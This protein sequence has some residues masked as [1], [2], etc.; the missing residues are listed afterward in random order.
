MFS[1]MGKEYKGRFT[2]ICKFAD[3]IILCMN[4]FL[5][6]STALILALSCADRSPS[7]APLAAPVI[8][9]ITGSRGADYSEAIISC[10]VSS[11]L[12]LIEFGIIWGKD[13]IVPEGGIVNKVFTARISGL[14]FSKTYPFRAFIGNGRTRV[15]SE[16]ETWSTEDETPPAPAIMKVVALPGSYA[17]HVRVSCRIPALDQVVQRSLLRCGVCYSTNREDPTLEGFS[18]KAEEIS[19]EGDFL[20]EVK[21]LTPSATY[22]MRPFAEIGKVVAYGQPVTVRV[23]S[24]MDIVMTEECEPSQTHVL[25]HGRVSPDW[26]P[27]LSAYGIDWDG[28]LIPAAGMDADGCF[29]VERSGL[30]PGKTYSYRAYATLEGMLYYGDKVSFTTPDLVIP[31]TEYVDLGLGVLWGIKNLGASALY[32]LGDKYAWGETTPKNSF[33]WSNYLWCDGTNRVTKYNT[34]DQLVLLPEDDAATEALHDGWRIPTVEE[35]REL[36]T[37]CRWDYGEVSNHPGYVVTSLEEGFEGQSFFIPVGNSAGVDFWSSSVYPGRNESFE[38]AWIFELFV[39]I[40]GGDTS[41]I[42][43][44]A[45][46]YGLRIRPVRERE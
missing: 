26:A 18:L 15:Y 24:E 37:K 10:E 38:N 20:L 31:E 44:G 46:C 35:W 7:E 25:M 29:S 32:A 19:P 6:L 34:P 3:R 2:E 5:T 16:T 22:W 43:W 4:R 12:G 36:M 30:N 21:G 39:P 9:S 28:H 33:S 8:V 1:L 14:E 27:S 40:S 17:G 41:R 42:N 11:T 13:E 45:R 23:P